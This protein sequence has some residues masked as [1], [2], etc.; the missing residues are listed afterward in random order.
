[1]SRLTI[2]SYSGQ[3]IAMG[4]SGALVLAFHGYKPMFLVAAA[5]A[6]IGFVLSLF[7]TEKVP[8]KKKEASL[9]DFLH[10]LTDKRG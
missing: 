6:L 4:I 10:I 9:S 8:E 1:M 7:I 3:A 5:G 2:C